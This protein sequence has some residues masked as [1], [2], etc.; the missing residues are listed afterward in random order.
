[1]NSESATFPSSSNRK[2]KKD[3]KER[4]LSESSGDVYMSVACGDFDVSP[5]YPAIICIYIYINHMYFYIYIYA[6]ANI[7]VYIAFN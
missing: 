4:C 5:T 2:S 6:Y 7:F 3:R 1:M